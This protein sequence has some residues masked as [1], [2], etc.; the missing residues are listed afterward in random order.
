MVHIHEITS[1]VLAIVGLVGAGLALVAWKSYRA[2][3]NRWLPYVFGAFAILGAKGFV[4]AWAIFTGRVAHEHLELLLGMA[5]LAIA[6][7]LA[8]PL[9]ARFARAKGN[10]P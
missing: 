4:G 1:A 7:L 10:P 6:L 8:A 9:L 3:A 2:T 5:D